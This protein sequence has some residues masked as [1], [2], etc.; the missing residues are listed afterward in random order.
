MGVQYPYPTLMQITNITNK[1][2]VTNAE[3]YG[4]GLDICK[5]EGLRY[6][7]AKC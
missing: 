1:H 2:K 5:E 3:F 6:F 4:H 7:Y